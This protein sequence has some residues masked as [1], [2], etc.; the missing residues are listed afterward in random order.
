MIPAHSAWHALARHL[1]HFY[2][3]FILAWLIEQLE[4]VVC[5]IQR[6]SEVLQLPSQRIALRR[7]GDRGGIPSGPCR[8]YTTGLLR[9]DVAGGDPLKQGTAQCVRVQGTATSVDTSVASQH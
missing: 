8:Q 4:D 1:N 2:S 5:Q 3:F 9:G 6:I 7:V